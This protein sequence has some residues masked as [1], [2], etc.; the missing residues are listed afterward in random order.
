MGLTSA[1]HIGRSALVSSQIGIQ[2]TG[3]NLANAATPGYA[4]Q[5]MFL[6]PTRGQLAGGYTLGRGVGIR[7]V[8]RQVDEAL[9][10]RLRRA[11]RARPPR[12]SGSRS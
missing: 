3:N 12:A 11:W 4:R 1:M 7:A 2:V 8:E 6:Q 10:D 5:V 9:Q